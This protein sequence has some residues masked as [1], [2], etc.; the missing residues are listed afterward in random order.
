MPTE[1]FRYGGV[2]LRSVGLYMSLA[3]GVMSAPPIRGGN[4]LIPYQTGQRWVPKYY[5]ER[6]IVLAG[7]LISVASRSDFQ[8]KID[9]LKALFPIGAGEQKLEIQ[10]ADGTFRYCMAEVLNTMG[11]QWLIFPT[12]SSA[13]SIELIASDP[14][15]YGSVFEG[16]VPRQAWT[17]DSG[18]FFDDTAHW[19]DV[20]A[21]YFA[22]TISGS[23][24]TIE[25]TNSGTYYNRKPIFFLT[26]TLVNPRIVNGHNGYSLQITGTFTSMVIDCGAQTVNGNLATVTLGAGQTDWMRLESGDNTL[27][28]TGAAGAAYQAQYSSAYL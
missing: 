14:M 18:V 7:E 22:Q 16:Q 2:D 5:D 12:R 11:L 21:T 27:T 20:E 23:P 9:A 26:G 13:F 8:A 15:W 10:R 24:A 3:D 4:V 19:F 6:H 28:I 1:V 25:A 17:L